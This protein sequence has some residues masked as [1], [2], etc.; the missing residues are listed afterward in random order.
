MLWTLPVKESCSFLDTIEL[1]IVTESTTKSTFLYSELSA[2]LEEYGYHNSLSY[3]LPGMEY[4]PKIEDT[5]AS[6]IDIATALLKLT[7]F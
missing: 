6:C 7:S 2:F 3:V 4:C 1:F 5:F